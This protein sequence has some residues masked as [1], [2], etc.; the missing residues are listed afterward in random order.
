MPFQSL[1]KLNSGVR[2]QSAEHED[3]NLFEIR[4]CLT[5]PLG[6]LKKIY[7]LLKQKRYVLYIFITN[8]GKQ[9]QKNSFYLRAQLTELYQYRVEP[10]KL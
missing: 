8:K 5:S 3:I 6:D 10:Q 2:S 1:L 9:C 4:K 7:M